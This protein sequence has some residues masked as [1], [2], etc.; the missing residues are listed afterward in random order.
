MI[1][2]NRY[3]SLSVNAQIA[4]CSMAYLYYNNALYGSYSVT[5]SEL[6]S[7]L[8]K[9]GL[10]MSVVSEELVNSGMVVVH[11][12]HIFTKAVCYSIKIEELLGV[13][14]FLY[15][16]RRAW[17]R[18]FSKFDRSRGAVD[19]IRNL[20]CRYVDGKPLPQINFLWRMEAY[21]WMFIRSTAKCSG[22]LC[23]MQLSEVFAKILHLI[24]MDLWQ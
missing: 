16:E 24:T 11:M 12:G 20:L 23:V 21:S 13:Q 6:K 17:V 4:L 19:D 5:E 14:L 8:S 7:R 22:I 3:S 15:S 10:S 2:F 18:D 1:D 9:L